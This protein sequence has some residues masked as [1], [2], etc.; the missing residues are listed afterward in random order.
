MQKKPLLT[1]IIQSLCFLVLLSGIHSPA[2]SRTKWEPGYLVKN[3]G[4]T[5]RGLIFFRHGHKSPA[6]VS[7]KLEKDQSASVYKPIDVRMFSVVEDAQQIYYSSF[8][9]DIDHSTITL[10]QLESSPVVKPTR[11]TVF[12][13]LILKGKKSLY[14][15]VDRLNR[16]DHYLVT[17][18]DG[19]PTD[20]YNKRY[21][22]ATDRINTTYSGQYKLQ[23]QKLFSDCSKI[24]MAQIDATTFTKRNIIKLVDLYNQCTNSAPNYRYI[25][26]K[27]P[28]HFGIIAGPDL[29]TL[30]LG[31]AFWNPTGQYNFKPAT[32]YS[33]GVFL[34]IVSPH[35]H[36]CWSLYNEL[37]FNHY[38]M[39]APDF[40]NITNADLKLTSLKLL[41]ILRYQYQHFRNLKPFIEA[42]IGNAYAFQLS[43]TSTSELNT[44]SGPKYTTAP[45]T[46]Y[47]NYEQLLVAGIGIN[48]KALGLQLRYETGNGIFLDRDVSSSTKHIE[49]L[50]SFQFL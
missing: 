14:L 30:K 32:G 47:R 43:A 41:T 35:G 23:L 17:D 50:L 10:D 28:V 34:N 45:I 31:S 49:V 42:G 3:N 19:R 9:T 44:F 18:E 13:Q 1:R 46:D 15:Y 33:G 7:L 21:F 29:V 5:L 16:K 40:D 38:E 12:S 27:I 20:L 6:T 8:V 25:P 11:D 39:H 36:R 22:V 37:N 2:Y 24:T 48:Y 26:A 4:D